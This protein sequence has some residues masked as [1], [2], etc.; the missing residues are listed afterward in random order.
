VL[1]VAM[2]FFRKK[3]KVSTGA[4]QKGKG[5]RI[6]LL[7]SLEAVAILVACRWSWSQLLDRVVVPS[8][9]ARL[10]AVFD[11]RQ[12]LPVAWSLKI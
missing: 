11:T 6:Y 3:P 5:T 10:H 4:I 9:A 8:R 7:F 1:G 12:K 2:I